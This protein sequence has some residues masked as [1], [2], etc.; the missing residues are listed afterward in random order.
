MKGQPFKLPSYAFNDEPNRYLLNFFLTLTRPIKPQAKKSISAIVD[1]GPYFRAI[2]RTFAKVPNPIS[3]TLP[4]VLFSHQR[5]SDR[6]R[7]Q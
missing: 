5:F 1:T 2:Q 3:V 4:L 7:G 6:L